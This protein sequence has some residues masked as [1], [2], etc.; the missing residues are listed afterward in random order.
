MRCRFAASSPV[1]DDLPIADAVWAEY[2]ATE[3]RPGQEPPAGDN[4]PTPAHAR[5]ACRLLGCFLLV[6]AVGCCGLLV[7]STWDASGPAWPPS[8]YAALAAAG[9]TVGVLLIAPRHRL[10]GL[11]VGWRHKPVHAE[12]DRPPTQATFFPELLANS[13]SPPM[14]ILY[15][16]PPE[17]PDLQAAALE[18]RALC[19]CKENQ[20]L[21]HRLLNYERR[22][23]PHLG[24]ADLLRLVLQ[25]L[26][27]DNR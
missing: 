23:H 2:G 21:L 5:T 24:R 3:P 10:S 12:A 27:S 18:E 20:Q 13:A 14:V 15:D 11:L 9:G 22:R 1:I 25:R 17:A 8:A 7:V 19:L 16:P 4:G 26:E 6:S